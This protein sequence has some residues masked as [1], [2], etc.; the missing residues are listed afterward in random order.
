L[1]WIGFDHDPEK[2]FRIKKGER[3]DLL[4]LSIIVS[5]TGADTHT[6]IPDQGTHQCFFTTFFTIFDGFLSFFSGSPDTSLTSRDLHVGQIDTL[7]VL[8]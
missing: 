7:P 5:T 8:S 1:E 6:F 2:N 4:I 3:R